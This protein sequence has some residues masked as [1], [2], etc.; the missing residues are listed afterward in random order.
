MKKIVHI[1]TRLDTGGSAENVLASAEFVKPQEYESLILTGPGSQTKAPDS[2]GDST[3]TQKVIVV[4][5]LVREI[6]PLK[7]I[8]AF[9]EIFSHLKRIKP[10]IVHTHSS[11]AGVIGRWAAYFAGVKKIIHTPHGHVFYGYYSGFSGYIKTKFFLFAE[12]I[13]A[14]ITT[15]FI[16]LTEGEKKETLG[17]G[18]GKPSDWAVIHSGIDYDRIEILRSSGNDAGNVPFIIGTVARLEPVK[19]I[20]YFVESIPLIIRSLTGS[21]AHSPTFLIV[22]DGSQRKELETLTDELKISSI[23]KF[24]GMKENISEI[25]SS[26]DIYVQPSLNEG[27]G[28]TLVYAQLLGKPVVAT[29]VQGIPD[30]VIDGETG[31]L[32]PAADPHR[33]AEA[34]LKLII[35]EDLR[36][37]MGISA[38]KWANEEVDGFPRFSIKR[39]V[40]LLEKVY[41]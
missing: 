8:S 16:A 26:M 4:P 11:K 10:D 37:R 34:I 7:D 2:A 27:M 1:I 19:G 25:I 22:G 18:I 31:I 33:L 5:S 29:K 36:E 23:I 13:T 30:V 20:R 14:P 40:Y 17:Y 6:S 21:L 24:T 41:Q 9:I 28:K 15:K 3:G 35:D 38:G 39:M 32:V 12:K